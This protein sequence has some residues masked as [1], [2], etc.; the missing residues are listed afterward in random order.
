[1]SSQDLSVWIEP[2]VDDVILL[3]TAFHEL[4]SPTSFPQVLGT[5]CFGLWDPSETYIKVRTHL[6]TG[7]KC[8]PDKDILDLS[9]K[10]RSPV[11]LS[12]L[13]SHNLR[14]NILTCALF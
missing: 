12:S 13:Q 4:V 11:L 2:I 14:Y 1:M 10:V 3:V 5:R 8:D 9:V 7:S 6:I